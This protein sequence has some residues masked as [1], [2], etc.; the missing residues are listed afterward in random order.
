[1]VTI[2][3]MSA[4]GITMP[5]RA[6]AGETFGGILVAPKANVG[7]VVEVPD[8][9]A[10]LLW[11]TKDFR[12]LAERKDLVF[13]GREGRSAETRRDPELPELERQLAVQRA[14]VSTLERE[15]A[16]LKAR[17][18]DKALAELSARGAAAE[19][20]VRELEAELAA[21][22]KKKDE[23]PADD[24]KSDDKSDDKS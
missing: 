9:Y 16:E 21:A 15:N 14:R 1:M 22:L 13:E 24:K 19:K 2:K 8:W 20:R 3:N 18:T 12:S 4:R 5:R 10:R 6:H 11:A 7:S 17:K 23:K